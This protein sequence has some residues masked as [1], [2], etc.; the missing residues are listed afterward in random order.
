MEPNLSASKKQNGGHRVHFLYEHSLG[1]QH[2]HFLL[3][4]VLHNVSPGQW[5][6]HMPVQSV[7]L[8]LFIVI[9]YT[10]STGQGGGGSLKNRKPVGE[11]GC[12]ES[13]IPEQKH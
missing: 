8:S 5:P 4:V 3:E 13:L 1:A 11:I 9:N 2:S 7:S 10:S 6:F 12:C